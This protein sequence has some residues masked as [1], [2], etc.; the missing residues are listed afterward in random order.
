MPGRR[1]G[2]RAHFGAGLPELVN[3]CICRVG[4]HSLAWQRVV[5]FTETG[6]TREGSKVEGKLRGFS[7]FVSFLNHHLKICLLI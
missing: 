7:G 2:F 1:N 4:N 6:E 5:S 3:R